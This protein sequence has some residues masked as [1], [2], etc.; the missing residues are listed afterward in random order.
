MIIDDRYRTKVQAAIAALEY[1]TTTISD[2]AR[3]TQTNSEDYWGIDCEPHV[4]GACPFELVIR[5]DGRHDLMIAG[6]AYEDLQTDDLDLFLPLASAIAAGNV[7]R[8]LRVSAATGAPF[9]VDTIVALGKDREW[10]GY[11]R[12]SDDVGISGQG[13]ASDRHFLPYQRSQ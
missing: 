1:W 5:T 12:T 3:I 8:R 10:R 13:I 2:A 11:R 6:E 7:T 4:K 9:A